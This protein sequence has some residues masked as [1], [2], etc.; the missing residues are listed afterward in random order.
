MLRAM[1]WLKRLYA[2]RLQALQRKKRPYTL[3]S[4]EFPE[5]SETT[6]PG[7][8]FVQGEGAGRMCVLKAR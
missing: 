2:F 4:R 6:H 3:L 7:C 5:A 1:L 8:A